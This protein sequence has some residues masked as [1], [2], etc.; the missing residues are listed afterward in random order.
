[1]GLTRDID[2][3]VADIMAKRDVRGTRIVG[4]DGPSGSDST[5]ASSVTARITA[6]C[7]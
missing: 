7:G 2:D 4:I 1:M 5:A 6:T 3:L